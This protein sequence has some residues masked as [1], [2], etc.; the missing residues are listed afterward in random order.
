MKFVFAVV[1]VPVVIGITLSFSTELSQI[2]SFQA[3]VWGMLTYLFFHIFVYSFEDVF[4]FGQKI[5]SDIFRFSTAVA[6]VV[7]LSVPLY[8]TLL[9]IILYICANVFKMDGIG[10]VFVFLSGFALSLHIILTAQSLYRDDL[11]V[12][13]PNYFS[14]IVLVYIANLCVISLLLDINF[15][16][17][18]FP[19]FLSGLITE[20][21]DIYMQLKDHLI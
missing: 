1:L 14:E 3:F 21:K 9:L 11:D 5:F 6:T 16:L 19:D 15:A 2:H 4:Y 7:T 13:K 17:F 12:I 18:S 10:P 20:S 8:A